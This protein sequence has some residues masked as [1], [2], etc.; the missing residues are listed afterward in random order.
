MGNARLIRYVNLKEQET[1]A[2][3]ETTPKDKGTPRAV[4]VLAML[5][6]PLLV[7]M[8]VACD[9]GS[10]STPRAP[11]AD[12]PEG[13]PTGS[14]RPIPDPKEVVE[15]KAAGA[16]PD[17]VMNM[18][19]GPARDTTM[20]L[21]KG[22]V[23]HYDAYSHIPCYCGCAAY[24]TVHKSLADCYVKA[25]PVAGGEVTFTDHSVTCSLCQEAAQMTVDGLAKSTPL[26]DIRADVFTKLKY[27]G[28]WTDTPPVP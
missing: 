10:G 24:T 6:L 1:T 13:K 28:I 8:V 2:L 4:K 15:T 14:T 27:T 25:P 26:K 11:Y 12:I 16:M 17:F 19:A 9:S 22:A 3:S 7:A 21:Y 23:D 20:A 5:L 18:S